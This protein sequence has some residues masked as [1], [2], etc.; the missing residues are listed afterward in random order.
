MPFRGYKH[1]GGLLA[2]FVAGLLAVAIPL[3]SKDIHFMGVGLCALGALTSYLLALLNRSLLG[4][5]MGLN[6]GF[7]LG[8]VIL[9]AGIWLAMRWLKNTNTRMQQAK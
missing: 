6:G 3:L 9:V 4:A 1:L 5:I 8:L 2:G 7:L